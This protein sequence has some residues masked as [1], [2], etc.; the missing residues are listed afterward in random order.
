MNTMQP[1]L[2]LRRAL[3]AD[4]LVG[5]L[6]S[7]GLML[8]S[9][10]LSTLLHLPRELLFGSGLALAPLAVF[11]VWLSRSETIPRL[12]VWA[13]IAINAVWVVDSLLLLVSGWVAPNPLGYAFVIGQALVVLLFIE[14]E[15]MGLKRSGPLLA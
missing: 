10:W 8:F 7:I 5:A 9:D 14:L 2:L 11:L 4:G 12:A 6:T 1:A 3:L 15:L 13:V